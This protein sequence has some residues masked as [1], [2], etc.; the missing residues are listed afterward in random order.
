MSNRLSDAPVAAFSASWQPPWT[1]Q[2]RLAMVSDLESDP[3]QFVAYGTDGAAAFRV[4][5][6]KSEHQ[7]AFAD[8]MQSEGATV[9]PPCGEAPQRSGEVIINPPTIPSCNSVQQT[10]DQQMARVKAA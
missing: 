2:N 9:L 10:F 1:G 6:S 8:L 3:S 5:G 7:A 4:Q